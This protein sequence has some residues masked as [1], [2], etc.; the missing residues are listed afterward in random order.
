MAGQ[1][2]EIGYGQEVKNGQGL[3]N[4]YKKYFPANFDPSII[5]ARS[6]DI[7][8]TF[9]SV[10]ALLYGLYPPEGSSCNS[11]IIPI[12]TM[13]F[14]KENMVPN[15]TWCTRLTNQSALWHASPEYKDYYKTVIAPLEQDIFK[16]FGLKP[17]YGIDVMFDC[18]QASAC[19]KHAFPPGMTQDLYTRIVAA[20]LKSYVDE[21]NFLVPGTPYTSMQMAMGSFIDDLITNIDDVVTGKTNQTLSIFSG[22]DVTVLP[23]LL[24]FNV[25]V[26]GH[27]PPYAS[28]ITIE[29]LE[30]P[31]GDLVRMYYNDQL[32]NIPYCKSSTCTYEQ[33]YTFSKYLAKADS[34]CFQK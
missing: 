14:D 23:T 27:W 25:W 7:P 34:N 3:H 5:Y 17:G 29:V 16:V 28:M 22:H 33:F 20:N 30:G 13:D 11:P 6:T 2:T 10:E 1:L 19:H 8:R 12:N 18:V 15:P 21:A 24:A 32:L 26:D 31:S 4:L 9:L